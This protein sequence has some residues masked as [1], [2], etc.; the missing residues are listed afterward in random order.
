MW[1]C[2]LLFCNSSNNL[3]PLQQYKV[4]QEFKKKSFAQTARFS[5][6]GKYLALGSASE[7]YAII[8]LG[9]LLGIDFVPLNGGASRLPRWALDETLFRSGYGASLVQRHMIHG[10]Q[11]SILWV[12]TTLKEFPDAIY[13]CNRYLEEGCLNTALR[14]KKT[15]LLMKSNTEFV[16]IASA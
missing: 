5:P 2:L 13:T 6:S 3:I 7:N 14:L 8:R 15:K 4:L 10:S 16:H 12:A 11:E 9:P 1:F